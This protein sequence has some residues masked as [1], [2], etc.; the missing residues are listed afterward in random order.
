MKCPRCGENVKL[1]AGIK[2]PKC[3]HVSGSQNLD[4]DWNMYDS[5]TG[6]TNKAKDADRQSKPDRSHNAKRRNPL[7]FKE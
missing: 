7:D 3:D 4:T 5:D 2:C 6:L 1:I